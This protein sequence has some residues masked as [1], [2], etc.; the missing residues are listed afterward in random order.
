MK[1]ID[2]GVIFSNTADSPTANCCFPSIARLDERTLVASW[3]IGSQKDS[4]DGT[5]LISHSEDNGRTWGKPIEPFPTVYKGVQGDL[6]YGP[7]SALSGGRMMISLMWV[8]HSEPSL[9]FFN[10]ETEGLLPIRTLLYDSTD[11]GRTWGELREMDDAPYRSPMPATGPIFE[12]EDGTLVYPFEV[13]KHYNEPQPWRH[14]AALK[15]S[16]DGGRTW[17]GHVEIANDPSGKVMY[18]DQHHAR[19]PNPGE[20]LVAFWVYDRANNRDG[21]IHLARSTDDGRTWSKPWDTRIQGQVAHPIFLG[22]RLLLVY[23]DR[24]G[25]RGIRARVSDDGGRSFGSE[26]LSVY[27]QPSAKAD[28]G[29]GADPS[30]YLQDQGLWTFGRVEGVSDRGGESATFSFYAGDP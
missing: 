1:L 11:G 23:V 4:V 29:E 15:L 16:T 6:R 7:V 20:R 25:S 24:F 17:P 30:Q 5:V 8:D 28:R 14:A 12:A 19:G 10:P 2:Q 18:W 13:N 3:R 22:R 27:Q 26:E 21:P 9:P